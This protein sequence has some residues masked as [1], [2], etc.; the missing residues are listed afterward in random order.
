MVIAARP[1]SKNPTAG[2]VQWATTGFT[3][4]TGPVITFTRSNLVPRAAA[5][6]TP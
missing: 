5:E 3:E 2:I 6:A 4:R 1:S